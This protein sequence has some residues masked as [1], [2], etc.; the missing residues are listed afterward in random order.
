MK[1]AYR[2]YAVTL[3][4]LTLVFAAAAQTPRVSGS[5]SA[6]YDKNARSAKDDR[7]T[8]PTV[9]T[10][11]PVGG[12]TGL[13]TV[14]DG[15]TLRKGEWTL[16]AAWSNYDRD[17]GNA[18]FTEIPLS[19]QYG[20]T[21]RIE[22]FFSTTALRGV[23][24]NSPNNLSSF[25]LPNS[26]IRSNAFGFVSGPAI[27]LAPQGPGTSVFGNAAVFR[28]IG[29]APWCVF[30]YQGCSAGNFGIT[31]V[32]SG[33]F[34]GFPVGTQPSIGP[35]RL[36]GGGSSA[37][38]FPGL[39]S[40]YGSILPG[41]VLQTT[42]LAGVPGGQAPSVFA[43]AP[44][45][46]PDAPFINREWG[47]SS[48]DDFNV[49]VKWRFTSP[50]NPVGIGVIAY[51]QW[52][53]DKV[54]EGGGF[55]MLQRGA[56][57]GGNKGDIGVVLFGG[58]RLRRWMNLSANVG[59]KWTS[60]VKGDFPTG[61]FTLLDRPD[62]LQSSIGVDFPINRYVQPIFEFRSLQYVSGRTPNSFE[63]HPLEALAGIRIF[64]ARWFGFGA[65]YRY[66]VNEQ[67][68]N[69]FHE[70]DQFS[71]RALVSC[72]AATTNVCTP[73]TV[74]TTFSGMPPGFQP[75][76]DP[77]GF[78]LQVFAGRRN[79]RQAEVVN[80][81][82]NVTGLT[83]SAS[84]ITLPCQPGYHS[85]SNGCND[86]TSVTVNTVAVDPEGDVLT[87]NYTTSAGRVVGTGAS[88]SWDLS[89]VAPGSYTITAGVDDGCGICGKTMTQTV[90][91]VNCPDCQL[92]CSCPT[93]GVSGPAGVTQPGETMTFTA[94]VSGGSQDQ[95]ITYNWTVSAGTIES[96]QG[97]PSIVVR[98][99]RETPPTNVTATLT[100]G[101]TRA[102]C[103]CP[104]T[105]SE[106][107]G[108][109][110][111][112]QAR[113]V[114][115][116]GKLSND[117][118]KARVQTFYATLANE[119]TSQ[120]YIIIYGTPK[121]IAARKTQITKAISF[122]KLDPSRVTIVEGG[123]KGTGPET[124]FWVVPPGATPPAP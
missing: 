80:Q 28:P 115:T 49:G 48:F 22:L 12:P 10:G 30:P 47:T 106:T 117:D 82:P 42:P 120:G 37:D 94:N 88:V 46:L 7:N 69:S 103:S 34:F 72:G 98:V 3:L 99:P 108:V 6:T 33:P 58:V 79:K 124:H 104:T 84:T 41:V 43:L 27:I 81:P 77:H 13:F 93:I 102:E 45:Y 74:T 92:N 23:K 89:G 14:Y 87:Y 36:G 24:V 60:S 56:S 61:T 39:G 26:R 55:N 8:A 76:Q 52:Y 59:Y 32:Q 90:N 107:A 21:N 65:A 18:D 78:I 68:Q 16:S 91:I 123:D 57:P 9:G 62:E 96:G 5:A 50:Q 85:A 31:T 15:D 100:I 63:N 40:V 122:L 110:P 20:L 66:H 83:L 113:E 121:E 35:P 25:Y 101:G 114:D 2:A 67:D 95:T 105:A 19:F 64:P 38:V 111:L 112:P 75:S 51:Y 17:P 86:S 44:T 54:N 119:P 1:L 73:V 109:A 97:T 71:S 29:T 116:F 4:L 53:Y 118:V 70:D 11:G